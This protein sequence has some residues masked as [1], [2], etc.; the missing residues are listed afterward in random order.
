MSVET[1]I[2]ARFE[3]EMGRCGVLLVCFRTHPETT[4]E[5]T[6]LFRRNCQDGRIIFVKNQSD[7]SV[8]QEADFVVPE[9]AGPEAIIRALQA[10]RATGAAD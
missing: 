3:I 7:A 6:D 5:L 2:Q 8:P 4:R 1:E 10:E 9:S